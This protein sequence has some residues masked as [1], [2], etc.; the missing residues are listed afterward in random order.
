[1]LDGCMVHGC[2][3]AWRVQEILDVTATVKQSVTFNGDTETLIENDILPTLDSCTP[4]ISVPKKE[5]VLDW[6]ILVMNTKTRVDVLWQDGTR[7]QMRMEEIVKLS[8]EE[9]ASV[10]E[11]S[12]HPDYNYCIGDIVLRLYPFSKA[13]EGSSIVH[14]L[15]VDKECEIEAKLDNHT[16]IELSLEKR[17]SRKRQKGMRRSHFR[18]F[19]E[20]LDLEEIMKAGDV[21]SMKTDIGA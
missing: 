10:Y 7:A 18:Q 2:P 14:P 4:T 19:Q 5:D 15:V 1:M 6:A 17:A 20:S 16:K 9:V 12:E 21:G 13:S 8:M 11:L 3:V